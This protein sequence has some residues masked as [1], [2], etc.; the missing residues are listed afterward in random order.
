MSS[1]GIIGGTGFI[2]ARFASLAITQGHRVTLFNRGTSQETS[3]METVFGDRKNNH[4]LAKFLERGFD[5]IFD[6]AAF[7]PL[8][9]Q[10]VLGCTELNRYV[11]LSTTSV[12]KIPPPIPVGVRSPRNNLYGT[13]GGEKAFA[14]N[15]L[16]EAWNAQRFPMTIARLGG[17]LGPGNWEPLSYI[18]ERISAGRPLFLGDERSFRGTFAHVDDVATALLEVGTNTDYLGRVINIA[19]QEEVD[20]FSLAHICAN[21]LERE[22]Q[23]VNIVGMSYSF[24]KAGIPWIDHTLVPAV[25][26]MITQFRPI[27]TTVK[28]FVTEISPM[29]NPGYFNGEARLIAR[30]G[31]PDSFRRCMWRIERFARSIYRPVRNQLRHLFAP[32]P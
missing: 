1:I 27:A 8:D 7:S 32:K 17:V 23:I 15:I 21:A 22:V 2:S 16:L 3:I 29:K 11:F 30:F 25:T 10:G 4:D 9:V 26:P 18:C 6:F 28:T 19:S 24:N 13:Y 20:Q 14:E 12:Y 31:S 5:L